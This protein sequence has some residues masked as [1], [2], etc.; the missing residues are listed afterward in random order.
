VSITV[1]SMAVTASRSAPKRLRITATATPESMSPP[2]AL[3]WNFQFL[4]IAYLS[5]FVRWGRRR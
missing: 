5:T 2:L 3:C 4:A 1:R